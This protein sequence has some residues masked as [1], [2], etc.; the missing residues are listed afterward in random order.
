[1]EQDG[2][3]DDLENLQQHPNHSIYNQSLKIIDKYFQEENGVN[4]VLQALGTT[5]A[6]SGSE[7]NITA[8][9]GLFDL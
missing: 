5:P 9:G 1:M 7:G 8:G 3:L 4:P 2:L 6:G